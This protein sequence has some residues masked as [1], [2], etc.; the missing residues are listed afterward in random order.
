MSTAIAAQIRKARKEE[1]LTQEQLAELL[2]VTRTAISQ[3]EKDTP[4]LRNEH[5][6][7]LATH[8]K[9]PRSTFARF[10]GDTVTTTDERKHA[11]PL[12]NWSE[13]KHVTLGGKVLKEALRKPTYLEVGKDVSRKAVAFTIAD[14]SMEEEFFAGEEVVID[15]AL[16]PQDDKDYVLV[17]LKSGEHL[18]RRYR[19]RDGAYDLVAI[20]PDWDTV[21]V[22]SKSP[23]EII[24]T[25]VEH[26]RK[27]R[28]R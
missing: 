23:A 22:S 10:G 12:L 15:P 17:R 26:R 11:I 1:G 6:I 28:P 20:N 9:R 19:P 5:I 16:Q 21:S 2:G 13:L 3:W 27:R 4:K 25:M 14:D 18:F 7:G 8:L 24:G